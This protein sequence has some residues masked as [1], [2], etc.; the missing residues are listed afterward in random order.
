MGMI[1]KH[2][3]A[4]NTK[5]GYVETEP[6]A[7]VSVTPTASNDDQE[8]LGHVISRQS[9][10][11]TNVCHVCNMV[12]KFQ[13]DDILMRRRSVYG[14]AKCGKAFHVECFEAFHKRAW[15]RQENDS[16][17]GLMMAAISE[18]KTN[19]KRRKIEKGF[20]TKQKFPFVN[21]S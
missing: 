12:G 21:D 13:K 14:C 6:R 10:N 15:M 11:K 19:P 1:E 5:K 4:R 16:E 20:D 17:Y 9:N 8:L 3:N 7:C 18:S 2:R